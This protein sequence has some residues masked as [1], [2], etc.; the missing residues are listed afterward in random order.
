MLYK[1]SA[2][3]EAQLAVSALG[4]GQAAASQFRVGPGCSAQRSICLSCFM[5]MGAA[6]GSPLLELITRGL[7][8][9]RASSLSVS[10]RGATVNCSLQH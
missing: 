1:R 3:S 4:V 6:K 7:S 5:C 2:C 8:I 9:A 10:L